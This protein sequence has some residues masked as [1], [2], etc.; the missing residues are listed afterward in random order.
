MEMDA[1]PEKGEEA[2]NS[3][4]PMESDLVSICASLNL[5]GAKYLVVG[6]WAMIQA[7]Y[8]RFTEDIDLLIS[9]DQENE[10]AVLT[11]LSQLPDR[12]A[13]QVRVGDVAQYGVVR[14][15]DEVLI[16]LM[17]S[18]CGI[19]Y[20]E[21]I[22]DVVWRELN[23]VRIPFASKAVL[24]KMKQTLREKDA[25]DRLFLAKALTEEG[26]TLDPPLRSSNPDEGLP[27]WA[28]TLIRVFRSFFKRH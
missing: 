22:E 3:R 24:W 9:T 12:A 14:I 23:G 28:K 20:A 11:A 19:T 6:G 13:E 4:P 26:I 15:G 5:A 7:G 18:G 10:S 27:E 8:P 16:D 1:H 17:K 2:L 25:P 21:A